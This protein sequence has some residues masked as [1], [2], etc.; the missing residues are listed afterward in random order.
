MT[1]RSLDKTASQWGVKLWE[2]MQNAGAF[3]D[4]V[5][6][7]SGGMDSATLLAA[8]LRA[9]CRPFCVSYHLEPTPSVD[10]V[11]AAALC[12]AHNLNFVQVAIP[13]T[14]AVHVSLARR[15]ARHLTRPCKKTHLQCGI[16]LMAMLDKLHAIGV[17][18][19]ERARR[20][21]VFGTG[22]IVEDNRK[23]AV[24][25]AAA[26]ERAARKLRRENLLGEGDSATNAM[27]RIVRA[28]GAH[29]SEPY[30]AEPLASF[31]LALTMAEINR[32]R[33]KGIALRA[34][35]EFF[36]GSPVWRPNTSL[37]VNSGL[38]DY[39]DALARE[40]GTSAIAMLRNWVA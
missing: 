4:P 20:S 19:K 32:P 7:L 33:Q 21:F 12:H 35:P 5:L 25:V 34:F 17:G 30:S 3:K 16:P 37:Q 40:S 22:G 36:A 23:C 14:V 9:G 1:G 6:F 11:S 39:H 10:A 18:K 15:A 8:M 13:R 29:Y 24:L 26:G 31:A 2:A 38:R 27:K 28:W